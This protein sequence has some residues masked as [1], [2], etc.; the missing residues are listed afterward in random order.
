[1]LSEGIVEFSGLTMIER[2][3]DEKNRMLTEMIHAGKGKTVL[4]SVEAFKIGIEESSDFK[5]VCKAL[6]KFGLSKNE[7]RVFTYLAKYGEQKAHKI[8]KILSLHRTETY[9]ILKR[10]EERGL[11]Y[12]ILDKPIKFAVVPIDKALENLVQEEK[13]KIKRLEEEKQKIIEK[14]NSMT[15]PVEEEEALSEFIQVLKGR[16]Q[17]CIKASEIIENAED[18]ILIVASNENLLQLFY[19]GVMDDLS[20]RA[21]KVRVRLVTDSSLRST[22][23]IKKLGL[24]KNSIFINVEHMPSFILSEK[25]LLLFLEDENG[26]EGKRALWTNQKGIIDSL[27]IPFLNLKVSSMHVQACSA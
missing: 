21:K 24:K 10:L 18:E 26:R 6:I 25:R 16:N 8:S 27:R 9:K 19:A 15:I 3:L 1:M 20:K 17:I 13:Q 11:A 23:I 22:Y 14:W 4:K 2:L 5:E 7:A 12:R